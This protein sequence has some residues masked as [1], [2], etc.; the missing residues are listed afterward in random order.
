MAFQS[1]YRNRLAGQ[2]SDLLSSPEK[3]EHQIEEM[4]LALTKDLKSI[5]QDGDHC[6]CLVRLHNCSPC[7]VTPF[8]IDFKGIPIE[9]P[10]LAKGA[11]IDLNTYVSHLWFFKPQVSQENPS[12]RNK[13]SSTKI[14]AIPEETL[15][16]SVLNISNMK[17]TSSNQPIRNGIHEAFLGVNN[18]LICSLCKFLLNNHSLTPLTVPCSHFTGKAKYSVTDIQC[19]SWSSYNSTY[20]YSCNQDTHR[21][22]HSLSRRNI[23]L[24]EPFHNLRE[25]CF[26]ELKD[27]IRHVDITKLNLPISL[28]EEYLKFL[29]SWQKLN[30]NKKNV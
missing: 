11:S 6:R 2:Y 26:L 3:K 8:W 30:E 17:P 14:L 28:Q 12:S 4:Y 18:S 23:Y 25:R 13:T 1:D 20:I 7:R 16:A 9:Y 29:T 10:T 15:S 22:E 21:R 5:V 24:V 19:R 27:R